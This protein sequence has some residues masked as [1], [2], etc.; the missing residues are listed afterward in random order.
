MCRFALKIICVVIFRE[1]FKWHTV[2]KKKK[3]WANS[4]KRFNDKSTI[5]SFKDTEC[6]PCHHR[7]SRCLLRGGELWGDDSLSEEAEDI[8]ADCRLTVLWKSLLLMSTTSEK[9]RSWKWLKKLK[10]TTDISDLCS[11]KEN[12][13]CSCNTHYSVVGVLASFALMM[14]RGKRIENKQPLKQITEIMSSY[15]AILFLLVSC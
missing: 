5:P 14:N 8:R 12:K 3:T 9:S 10:S 13:I 7:V 2:Q 15:F 1:S 6:F 11:E 4:K